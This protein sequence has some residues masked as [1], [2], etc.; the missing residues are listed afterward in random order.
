MGG[1]KFRVTGDVYPRMRPP[2]RRRRAI[3]AALTT[4]VLLGL[5]GYGTLELVDVFSG[6]EDSSEARAGQVAEKQDCPGAPPARADLPEPS[7]ITVNVY[8]ATQRQGLAQDT[9]DALAERGF[10]IGEV[11]NAPASLDGKVSAPALLL[12]GAAAERSGALTVLGTQLEGADTG[13]PQPGGHGDE[14][15]TVDFVIGDGFTR[16]SPAGESARRLAELSGQE[17]S[18]SGDPSG[19]AS[20]SESPAC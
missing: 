19:S 9:A 7:A 20:A 8:N 1:K 4:L 14:P 6:D 11:A 12:G 16:L 18:P 10:T 15:D 17:A 3:L 2:R 5:L 13:A